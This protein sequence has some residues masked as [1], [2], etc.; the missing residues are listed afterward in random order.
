MDS[1]KLT[2][3]TLSEWHSV[4]QEQEVFDNRVENKR[5]NSG[6]IFNVTRSWNTPAFITLSKFLHCKPFI[7]EKMNSQAALLKSLTKLDTR[8][9][10][11]KTTTVSSYLQSSTQEWLSSWTRTS[12]SALKWEE[13]RSAITS[14]AH[15]WLRF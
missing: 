2:G 11:T 3:V 8:R 13:M 10:Q 5:D 1:I 12:C 7:T 4:S 6:V 14:K 15:F 9:N